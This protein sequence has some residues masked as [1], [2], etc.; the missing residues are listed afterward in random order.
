[1]INGE[2]Q[3]IS[4]FPRVRADAEVAA[5][6]VQAAGRDLVKVVA[7]TE[8][9]GFFAGQPAD[10]RGVYVASQQYDSLRRAGWRL[11]A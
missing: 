11:S 10:L 4:V 8:L 7:D 2:A 1:M 6:V 5:K 9:A 3:L